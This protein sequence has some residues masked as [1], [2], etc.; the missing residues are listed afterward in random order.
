[1]AESP[2]SL[3][4]ADQIARDIKMGKFP[5]MSETTK[6]E[7]AERE[8]IFA[9]ALESIK[10]GAPGISDAIQRGIAR[11]IAMKA[12]TVAPPLPPEHN[13]GDISI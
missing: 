2:N 12:V 1:M 9:M 10:A 4:S 7:I 5:A 6:A 3:T 13:G 8:R 11:S